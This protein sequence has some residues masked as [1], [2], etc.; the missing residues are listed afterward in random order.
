MPADADGRAAAEEAMRA[1]AGLAS[2]TIVGEQP[3]VGATAAFSP[4]DDA[5]ADEEF[6]PRCAATC[7]A[8]Q[9]NGTA[10]TEL[11]ARHS[12]DAAAASMASAP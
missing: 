4:A 3:C 12:R 9:C 2:V 6:P 10:V 8:S 11:S 7:V 5:A 1:V